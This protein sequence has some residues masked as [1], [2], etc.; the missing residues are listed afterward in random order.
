M[1]ND[2]ELVTLDQA[3]T[4]AGITDTDRDDDLA[5]KLEE[6][7]AVVLNYIY[8]PDATWTAEMLAWTDATAPRQIRAAI[9]RQFADLVRNR[10]DDEDDRSVE[11]TGLNPRV[12]QLLLDYKQWTVA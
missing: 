12:E 2:L 5:L 3:K 4:H 6:A 7:H 9:S 8:R 1:W 11:R 10:G